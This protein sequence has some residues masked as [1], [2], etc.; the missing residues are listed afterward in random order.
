MAPSSA[1]PSTSLLANLRNELV[2]WPP[3]AQMSAAHV[4]QC[5]RSASQAYYA[6]GETVL[7]PQ[8]GPVR[9][10]YLVRSGHISGGRVPADAEGRFQIDAG[11]LFPVGALM[12]GR[13]VT[14][15]YKADEDTFCLLLPQAEV[16]ALAAHSVP[17][18]DFLNARMQRLLDLSR[19]AWRAEHAAQAW[20]EQ[21]IES[22]L[23]GLLSGAPV[24]AVRADVPLADALALMDQRRIGSVLV[25]DTAEAPVGILTRHDMIG[26]IILP[27]LSLATPISQ[28]MSAP[29]HS[30][31]IGASALDAAMLMSRRGIRHVPVTREGRVVGII[32]ERDLFSMQRQSIKQAGAA[33]RSATGLSE[34]Q[35]AAAE[36]RGLASRLLAQGIG[37]RHLTELISHLNDVLT[38][39]IVELTA[40]QHGLE[41]GR[42]CWLAFGSEGRNEQ[43]VATDQDNGLIFDSAD[44]ERDRPVWLA[45]ARQVNETLDACGYPLCRGNVMASNPACCLSAAEWV[46]R[47]EHWIEH[48]APEDL[49]KASIYFDFRP[50]AGNTAL[51]NPL[52]DIVT[53][54]AARTPRFIKQMADNALRNRSPL[55]WRG[56]IDTNQVDGRR[57]FDLKAQGTA[58]FVDL[59][60]LYALAHGIGETGTRRRFEAV[61]A[62]LEAPARES[63][64]WSNAF[65]FLQQLRLQV[66]LRTGRAEGPDVDKANLIEPA[67]LNDIDRRMLKECLRVLRRLRQRLELDYSR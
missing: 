30:L 42:C 12:A 64:S 52:R 48:G 55:D 31:D 7:C 54:G 41:L 6:P 25:T 27:Q 45:F 23:A 35:A 21:S 1:T 33:I 66:Q 58:I 53:G 8:D 63:E 46:A 4:E 39:R 32:S 43:T 19:S 28:V 57:V 37:A 38:V 40:A 15:T 24:A 67:A 65:E 59:A 16:Q 60:R 51:A 10:L 50:L 17:F 44:P 11:D 5:I 9:H 34:L 56:S 47:F 3:F 14:A 2:R 22:P 13:A 61:A 18:A 29:V 26:R 20:A 62:S 49:L 36:I